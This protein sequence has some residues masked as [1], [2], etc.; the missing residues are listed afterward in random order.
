MGR[1]RR[2]HDAAGGRSPLLRR[3]PVL[4]PA[5]DEGRTRLYRHS[6]RYHRGGVFWGRR[7]SG[8]DGMH[9]WEGDAVCSRGRGGAI[10]F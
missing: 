10:V 8:V 7:A 6:S 4:S 1:C 5:F 9:S 2:A 3:W